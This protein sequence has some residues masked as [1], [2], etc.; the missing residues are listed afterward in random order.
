ML[1]T[2]VEN[3]QLGFEFFDRRRPDCDAIDA[4]QMR[5]IGQ[6]FFENHRLVVRPTVAAIP[7]AEY[8][9]LLAVVR[10]PTRNVFDARR[11]PRPAER[12][13]PD[14]NHRHRE[15]MH[16]AMAV[17]EQPVSDADTDPVGHTQHAKADASGVA[18][19]AM[20]AANDRKV[21]LGPVRHV[22]T[23]VGWNPGTEY[24]RKNER[25]NVESET[26]KA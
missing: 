19:D 10:T 16:L 6:V 8:R 23:R 14:T 12:D 7:A 4:L 1:E 9:D 13:V 25:V 3:E 11:F 18:D 17:V 2:I 20:L 26:Q 15:F 24:H 21:S 22:A 5:H